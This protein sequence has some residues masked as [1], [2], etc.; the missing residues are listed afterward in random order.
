MNRRDF[1]KSVMGFAAVLAISP[2]ALLP[3][4]MSAKYILFSVNDTDINVNKFNSFTGFEPP[5]FSAGNSIFINPLYVRRNLEIEFSVK[6]NKKNDQMID[7]LTEQFNNRN[8]NE[9]KFMNKIKFTGYIT[10]INTNLSKE[11]TTIF[12]VTVSEYS[13]I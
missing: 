10:G 8:L 2:E 9:F 12:K 11:L 3:T 4:K 7:Y 1:I 6:I 13:K 5:S